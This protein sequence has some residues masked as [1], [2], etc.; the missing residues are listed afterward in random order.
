MGFALLPCALLGLFNT[1]LQTNLALALTGATELPGWRGAVLRTAG[2]GHDPSSIAACVALG[3]VHLLP[4][5]VVAYGTAVL[6]EEVFARV[7]GRR[8]VPGAAVTALLFV[9][10]LPPAIPLW[11]ASLGIA[12]GVVLAKELFGGT[13]RNVMHPAVV[14]LVLLQASFPAQARGAAVWT[15]VE[16]FRPADGIE[17]V[18]AGGM[19]ALHRAG[20]VWWEAFSGLVPGGLG[21]TSALGCALGAVVLVRRRAVS[22]RVVVGAVVGL[23]AAAWVLP[24]APGT[25]FRAVPWYWHA[26]LGQFAFGAVFLATDPVT[27]ACTNPGRLV[28]GA[29]VGA[30][31]VV[32]RVANPLQPDGVLHALLL[33]SV[34]APLIDHAV[35]RA[36]SRRRRRRG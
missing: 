36:N 9:L 33:G 12:A 29:L 2:V 28:H 22:W 31:V 13:G 30:L 27:S 21:C 14:G 8:R 23:A 19:E 15:A 11:Q 5:L 3:S 4:L 10:C 18:A 7:R 6:C 35:V 24:D 1:G 16:G 20:L 26:A 32:I 34:L 25:S 17:A